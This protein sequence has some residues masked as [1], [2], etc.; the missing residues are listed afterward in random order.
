MRPL[1]VLNA[2][3]FG[4]AAALTFA[5]TGVVIVFT[6]L[7]GRHPELQAEFGMLLLSSLSLAVLAGISGVSLF[8]TLKELRW[9][10]LAQVGM[11]GTLIA[12]CLLYWR[13]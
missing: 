13:W 3:V 2:I 4:S 8:A 6:L 11:W 12:M 1:A 10:W 5:L 7:K 9:R